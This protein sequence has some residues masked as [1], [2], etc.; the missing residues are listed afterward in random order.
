MAAWDNPAGYINHHCY[1]YEGG[2][3]YENDQYT[4]D[5]KEITRLEAVVDLT[6][7]PGS[8]VL[9]RRKTAARLV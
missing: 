8:R 7:E 2:A 4:G 5:S 6:E 3:L 1:R 9:K